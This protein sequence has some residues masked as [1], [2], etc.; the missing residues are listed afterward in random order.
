MYGLLALVFHITCA[1]SNTVNLSQGSSLMP[2][3]VL[4]Y[5]FS[6]SLGWP[7]AASVAAARVKH[8]PTIAEGMP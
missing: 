7:L 4:C 5:V 3:A 6:V 1:V 8:R 2:G